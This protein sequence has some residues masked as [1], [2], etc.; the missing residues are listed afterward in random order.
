MVQLNKAV[1]GWTS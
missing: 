1:S